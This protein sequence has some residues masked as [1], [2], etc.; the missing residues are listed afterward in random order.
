MSIS[1]QARRTRNKGV[2]A[3]RSRGKAAVV[4]LIVTAVV[5]AYM[6]S[7]AA[8]QVSL[9]GDVQ[10]G[11]VQN[12]T[13]ALSDTLFTAGA[14]MQLVMLLITGVLFLRWLAQMVNTA[15]DLQVSPPL[16]WT[17]SQAVWG[18]FIPFVNLARPYQVLRDL[19]DV[20]APDGVPEPAPRPRLDGASG[21]RKIEMEVPPPPAKLP[22]ASIGAWWAFYVIGG[23]VEWGASSMDEKGIAALV[24]SRTSSIISDAFDIVSAGLAIMVVVAISARLVERQRRLRHASDQELTSWGIDT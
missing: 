13:L 15:R 5:R 20:L 8:W 23:L 21:Y 11:V 2:K 6:A 24:S 4:A 22:H 7:V 1:S 16:A 9:L 10:R 19:H 14:V 3:A 17:A 12:G 18:F